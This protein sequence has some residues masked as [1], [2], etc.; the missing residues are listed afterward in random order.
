MLCKPRRYCCTAVRESWGIGSKDTVPNGLVFY[1]PRKKCYE[2]GRPPNLGPAL[3][4]LVRVFR[5]RYSDYKTAPGNGIQRAGNQEETEMRLEVFGRQLL[6]E[7]Y[8]DQW[9]VWHVSAGT[10]RPADDLVVPGEMTLEEIPEY[11]ADLCHEW[12]R[13]GADTVQVLSS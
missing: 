6:V 11:L 7:R 5:K 10:R 9:R 2:L 1:S 3:R 13:P 12:S 4:P 8:Q